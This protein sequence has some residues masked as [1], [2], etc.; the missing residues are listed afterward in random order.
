[1]AYLEQIYAMKA[2]CIFWYLC[3]IQAWATECARKNA[4]DVNKKAK[5]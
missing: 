3:P 2:Y 5:G 1:M 4:P